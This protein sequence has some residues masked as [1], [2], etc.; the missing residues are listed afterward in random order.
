MT[1]K[2]AYLKITGP[3]GLLAQR[4][5]FDGYTMSAQNGAAYFTGEL[6]QWERARFEA[7]RDKIVY[8]VKSY[9]TPIAWALEDG[10]VYHVAQRFST[11]TSK[12]QT[13]ARGWL[14]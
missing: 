13:Y 7:A 2:V 9:Q 11:T 1:V 14:R 10:T 5:Q 3:E 4:K 8:T 6:N 12:H